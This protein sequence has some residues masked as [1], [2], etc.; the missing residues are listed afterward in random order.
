[1]VDVG[2]DGL[3]EP[4][5]AGAYC[6]A[7]EAHLCRRNTGHLVRIVGPSFDLVSGWAERGVP[8]R[9][10]CRGIDRYVDRQAAKGPRRRPIRIEHCEADVLDVF[11]EW[12]RAIGAAAAR[13]AEDGGDIPAR[14]AGSL[15][16]HLERVVARLTALQARADTAPALLAIAATIARELDGAAFAAKGLR[17][18]ARAT[19]LERLGQLDTQ[20]LDAARDGVPPE[21]LSDLTRQA[22]QELRSFRDRMTVEAHAAAVGA[23]VDRLIRERYL[24]PF[25]SPD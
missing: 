12:R 25:V 6:R 18:E 17:G 4:A 23:L 9:V 7:V 14:R 19:F 16:A 20:L 1:V 2:S 24:L 11:D 8:L 5:D 21:A 10:A 3:E 13:P 22:E 15:P